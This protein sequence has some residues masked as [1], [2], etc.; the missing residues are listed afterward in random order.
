MK[1]RKKGCYRSE[2]EPLENLHSKL[3]TGHDEDDC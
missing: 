3:G 2:E 1:R